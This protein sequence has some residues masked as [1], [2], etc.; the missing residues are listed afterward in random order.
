MRNVVK[1]PNMFTPQ[2]SQSMFGHF[3]TCMKGLTT[4][5]CVKLIAN[6]FK[7]LFKCA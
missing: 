2:D 7:Q 6:L 4:L 1:W 3:T 5:D